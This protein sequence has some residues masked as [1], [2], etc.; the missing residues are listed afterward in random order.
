MLYKTTAIASQFRGSHPALKTLF[1]VLDAQLDFWKLPPLTVT[2]AH[3]TREEQRTLYTPHYLAKGFS[4][5]NA[6]RMAE[7]KF[8]WHLAKCALDFRS[9]GQPYSDDEEDKISLWL[10]DKCK[11]PPA[12]P[13]EPEPLT[14]ELLLHNLGYGR[15]FHVAVRDWDWHSRWEREQ[16]GRA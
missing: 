5:A 16:R 12:E 6:Q 14:W 2:D 13:G 7:N 4:L 3:R 15:H 11:A 10:D 8:S 9:S 1:F